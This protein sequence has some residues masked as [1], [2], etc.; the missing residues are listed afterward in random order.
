MKRWQVEVFNSKSERIG[1]KNFGNLSQAM[2]NAQVS[3]QIGRSVNIY[4]R[5]NYKLKMRYWRD[6]K[7]LQHLTY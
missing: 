7:G 6:K 4:N 2:E 3:C 1:G 5:I